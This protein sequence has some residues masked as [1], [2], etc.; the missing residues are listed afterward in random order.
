MATLQAADIG[1]VVKTTLRE[2]GRLRW[3]GI[4]SDLQEHVALPKMLK[5][6]RVKFSD[7]YEIQFNVQYKLSGNAKNVGLYGSDSYNVSDTMATGS[8]PWRHTTTFYAFDRREMTM[9]SGAS[10]I[11][12]LIKTRR[13]DAMIDLAERMEIDF[14]GAP[15]SSSDTTTPYGIDYWVVKNATEGFNGGDPSGFTAGAAGLATATYTRWKNWTYQ[16]TNVTKD[17]L[18]R[19]WRNAA[20]K[21]LF[22]SPVE[23]PDYNRGDRYG[24]YTN[25][26]VIQPLEELLEAQ[27]ENLGKDLASMDG[28]VMFRRNPVVWVPQ[29]DGDSQDPVYGINWGVFYPVFLAG[30]YMKEQGPEKAANQHTVMKVDIDTSYNWC[31]KNRRRLFILNKSA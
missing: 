19:G 1:D 13:T 23:F 2:L 30:E 29:L 14:W 20:T 3:T 28:A 9:N 25:Y 26:D 18:I 8:I 27:N 7:G 12:D 5:K 22:K 15:A 4:Q 16:Y 21:T 10:R 24:Y 31:C 11:V 17:D 6:E